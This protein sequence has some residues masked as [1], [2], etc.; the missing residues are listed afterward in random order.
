M[1]LQKAVFYS[2]ECDECDALS[3]NYQYGRLEAKEFKGRGTV[4]ARRAASADGWSTFSDRDLCPEHSGK[5]R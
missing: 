1:S 2:F 5:R 3:D 4:F